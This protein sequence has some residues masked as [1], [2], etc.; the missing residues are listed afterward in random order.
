MNKTTTNLSSLIN[1][2][3]RKKYIKENIEDIR[4]NTTVSNRSK[5][6]TISNSSMNSSDIQKKKSKMFITQN[7]FIGVSEGVIELP[8]IKPNLDIWRKLTPEELELK[9]LEEIAEMVKL[10][11]IKVQDDS[12]IHFEEEQEEFNPY[13]QMKTENE[14][15]KL[16]G[17]DILH[18]NINKTRILTRR[19]TKSILKF[20]DSFDSPSL[21]WFM[22]MKNKPKELAL[23]NRNKHIR[24]FFIKLDEEQKTIFN[25][26][27]NINKKQFNFDVFMKGIEEETSNVED[28]G[29]LIDQKPTGTTV[30]YYKEVMRNKVKVEEL[31][32]LDLTRLAEGLHL[33]KRKK[34]GIMQKMISVINDINSL[35][36]KKKE[37][38]ATSKKISKRL[39]NE[40]STSHPKRKV[41]N[42]EDKL[43]MKQLLATHSNDI[44]RQMK[45]VDNIKIEYEDQ[46]KKYQ[47][48]LNFTD[49]EIRRLKVK[50]NS[51]IIDH[52]KYYFEILKKGIDVRRDGLSWVIIKL[53]ELKVYFE[54]SKFPIFL[55]TEQIEYII[56]L[57]YKQYE[58]NE[59]IYL[60]KILKKKQ[61]T[62]REKHMNERINAIDIKQT[63]DDVKFKRSNTINTHELFQESDYAAKFNEIYS[64]Y[65]N[66]IN[67][68]LNEDNED[69]YIKTISKHLHDRIVKS[70][71]EDEMET[72]K[73]YFLPGSL[74]EFFNENNKF[75]QYFDDIFYLS[76]EISKRENE[77]KEIKKNQIIKFRKDSERKVIR[78]SI[79]HEMVF[80]ALFGNGI[81]I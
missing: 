71:E 58:M 38:L 23:L 10:Q 22:D 52:C 11:M 43:R 20:V 4:L 34:R 37:I 64:K 1:T 54:H 63:D 15:K 19:Q 69:L 48:Q 7:N 25:Q 27:L 42:K 70:K 77:I 40:S 74:A 78:N 24:D 9:H 57:A 6:K 14:I 45:E 30:E 26:S 61:K 79:E 62:M 56:Q 3:E 60:F 50:M 66:V 36:A 59:L 13:E 2:T 46:I 33:N 17:W 51:K 68:C 76:T 35:E 8:K 81:N 73:L 32:K 49:E 65:E 47:Q 12:N 18:A 21:K 39:P 41:S 29:S 16:N 5:M 28:K 31:F 80:A 67:I 44:V 72:D 55:N 75:R 53:I